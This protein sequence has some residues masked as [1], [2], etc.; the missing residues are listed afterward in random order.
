MEA[1][2]VYVIDTVVTKP[3]RA[4]EF[5]DA[6]L[7]D[8]APGARGRGMVLERIV[9]SPPVWFPDESNTVIAS[10]VLDGAQGWWTMT[11]QGRPDESVR[12][13]W[14]AA[15]EMIVERTRATGALAADV[16][17]LGDV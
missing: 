13:W 7:R 10:W 14:A 15:A 8:Y 12:Q 17:R 2:K 9:V 4:R 16:D 5:V 11:W 1:T 6:Y 3:G